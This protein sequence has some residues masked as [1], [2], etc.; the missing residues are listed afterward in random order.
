MHTTLLISNRYPQTIPVGPSGA[1]VLTFGSTGSIYNQRSMSKTVF[2]MVNDD[3]Y[4]IRS[5]SWHG[6]FR[7]LTW[8]C[9]I[10]N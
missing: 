5:R 9:I 1:H 2:A 8:K 4:E 6:Q 3:G 10:H 7:E